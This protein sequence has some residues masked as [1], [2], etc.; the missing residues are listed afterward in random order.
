MQ[1]D[2]AFRVAKLP[3]NAIRTDTHRNRLQHKEEREEEEEE[4][5][6]AAAAAIEL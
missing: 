2:A 5:R 6:A 3:Y 4:E 1:Q